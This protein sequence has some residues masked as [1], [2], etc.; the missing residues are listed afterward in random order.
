MLKRGNDTL[1]TFN[2]KKTKLLSLSRSRD[3]TFPSIHMGALTLY[4]PEVADFAFWD[5][6]SPPMP[7]GRGIS[8]ALQSVLP[9]ELVVYIELGSSYFLMLLSYFCSYF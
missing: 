6:V 4:L 9:C 8:Q 7:Y 1:V 3:D 5:F 2:A